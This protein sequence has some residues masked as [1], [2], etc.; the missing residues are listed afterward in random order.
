MSPV[1]RCQLLNEYVTSFEPE[2]TDPVLGVNPEL[3]TSYHACER[4]LLRRSGTPRSPMLKSVYYFYIRATPLLR[5]KVKFTVVFG[6]LHT[7]NLTVNLTLTL[8]SGVALNI[9]MRPLPLEEL[10]PRPCQHP[11]PSHPLLPPFHTRPSSSLVTPD[12][13][14]PSPCIVV[15]CVRR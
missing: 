7:G 6:L 9:P 15:M 11:N 12:P 10:P 14:I 2:H 5:V 13:F 8:K 4:C 3:Q 1:T